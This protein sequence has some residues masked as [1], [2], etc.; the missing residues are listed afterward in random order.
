[1]KDKK[2]TTAKKILWIGCLFLVIIV[3]L[4]SKVANRQTD[5][6][7]EDAVKNGKYI[8]PKKSLGEIYSLEREVSW[9]SKISDTLVD[10][11]D[12]TQKEMLELCLKEKCR[13]YL[14][15]GDKLSRCSVEKCSYIFQPCLL[16]AS[17]VGAA[18]KKLQNYLDLNCR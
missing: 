15:N 14:N 1:V 8:C 9:E 18:R 10:C 2:K 6:N 5:I 3:L 11:D 16:Q 12:I 17:K 13:D 4:A 7:I